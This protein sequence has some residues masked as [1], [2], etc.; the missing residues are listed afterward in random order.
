[1][2]DRRPAAPAVPA[3]LGA[4]ERVRLAVA[5][6]TCIVDQ[7]SKLWLLDVFDL[8]GPARGAR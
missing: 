4:V 8:A 2:T 3:V 7:A 6:L 1:M 5:L